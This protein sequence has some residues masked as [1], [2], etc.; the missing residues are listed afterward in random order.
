MRIVGYTSSIKSAKRFRL[1]NPITAAIHNFADELVEGINPVKIPHV[2][3]CFGSYTQR[4]LDTERAKLIQ[5][6]EK[7][8]HPVFYCDSA[9]Y[10]TYIRNSIDSSETQMFRIGLNS[11][12]GTGIYWKQDM[13][14]DRFDAFKN[15]F[16]FTEKEPQNNRDGAIVV[17]LQSETGW[18]YDSLEPYSRFLQNT[19][20][21]IRSASDRKIIIRTHPTGGTAFK[22]WIKNT[23]HHLHKFFESFENYEIHSADRARR[24]LFDSLGN[25]HSV[26]THSSSA[27]L[28]CVVQGIPTFA[29]D[30][31]CFGSGIYLKDLEKI[32]N[33]FDEFSWEKRQQWMYNLAYTSW[34]TEEMASQEVKDYYL[35]WIK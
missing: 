14:S 1:D 18:M 10:S 17:L 22:E 35:S 3:I 23:K 15:T 13:P 9:A 29:L 31:R 20:E 27:A 11:C 34:T 4:K 7:S 32:E 21:R 12:T 24:S 8:E 33:A 6:L 5:N 2:G 26:V 19:L 16:N 25:A 28:E 30:D